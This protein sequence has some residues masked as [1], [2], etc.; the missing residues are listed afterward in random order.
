MHIF[1]KVRPKFKS[2]M[3]FFFLY[4]RMYCKDLFISWYLGPLVRLYHMYLTY[5]SSQRIWIL[6]PL[7][8]PSFFRIC[9]SFSLVCSFMFLPTASS[10]QCTDMLHPPR[11]YPPHSKI[12]LLPCLLLIRC[13][14]VP[15]QNLPQEHELPLLHHSFTF[16]QFFDLLDSGTLHPP[17]RRNY[18]LSAIPLKHFALNRD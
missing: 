12:F 11:H 5:G 6:D 15:Q 2:Y 3:V 7:P 1:Y 4:L 17:V 9:F 16:H 14:R 8:H 18:F 13:C 10:P